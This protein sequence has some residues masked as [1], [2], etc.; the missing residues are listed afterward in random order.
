[1]KI[2]FEKIFSRFR[3]MTTRFEPITLS[4]EEN[5]AFE[6]EYLEESVSNQRL[7]RKFKTFKYDSELQ[8]LTCELKYSEDEESDE[9]FVIEILAIG[10]VISWYQ[11]Q[12]DSVINT[13]PTMGGKEEKKILDNYKSSINRFETLKKERYHM[14]RD[15]GYMYNS[16]LQGD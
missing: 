15:R 8:E 11:P 12:I 10:M 13:A 6:N 2:P 14:I 5:L 4:R 3:L 9:R 7:R 1:M 16:Y